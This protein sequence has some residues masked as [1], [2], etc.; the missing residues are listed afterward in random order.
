MSS[1][2]F[3]IIVVLLSGLFYSIIKSII[4][5]RKIK[6]QISYSAIDKKTDN[7]DKKASPSGV[8]SEPMYKGTNIVEDNSDLT[9]LVNQIKK[10]KK[11]VAVGYD[12][13]T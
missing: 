1:F 6:S 3:P 5:Y 2:Y 4:L 9:I 8:N 13:W 12:G 10:R 11:N 7:T